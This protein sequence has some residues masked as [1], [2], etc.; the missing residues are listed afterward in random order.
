MAEATSGRVFVLR[1]E[2][3]SSSLSTEKKAA[4][5][6]LHF[7]LSAQDHAAAVR[8]LEARGAERADVGQGDSAGWVVLRDPEGNESRL[9]ESRES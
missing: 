2:A 1:W 6:R 9:L 7:D 4:E 5:N 3:H 8:L